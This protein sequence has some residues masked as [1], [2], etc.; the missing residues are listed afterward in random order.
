[1]DNGWKGESDNERMV[2]NIA[3]YNCH[4]FCLFNSALISVAVYEC[5]LTYAMAS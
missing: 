2:I 1:M 5:C 3:V 4:L